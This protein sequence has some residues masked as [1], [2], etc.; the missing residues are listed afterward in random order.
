MLTL[1]YTQLQATVNALSLPT[2]HHDDMVKKTETNTKAKTKT[3]TY[4]DTKTWLD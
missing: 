3:K 1:I 4:P 2:D